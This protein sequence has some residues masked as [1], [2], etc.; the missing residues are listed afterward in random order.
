MMKDKDFEVASFVPTQSLLHN[1]MPVKRSSKSSKSRTASGK[2]R[3]KSS[4]KRVGGGAGGGFGRRLKRQISNTSVKSG[5]TKPS[6]TV[7]SEDSDSYSSSETDTTEG[8]SYSEE[9]SAEEQ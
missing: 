7:V 8:S 2:R 6:N 9:S 3:G 4:S 5:A 1:P